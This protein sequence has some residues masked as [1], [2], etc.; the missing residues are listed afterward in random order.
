MW[1]SVTPSTP[2]SARFS[3]ARP[4]SP[5]GAEQILDLGVDRG[6]IVHR[7]VRGRRIKVVLR[8]LAHREGAGRRHLDFAIRVAAQEF[9]ILDLDRVLATDLADDARN[10]IGMA[11]AVEGDAGIVDVDPF[12]RR[13]EPVRTAFAPDFAVGDDVQPRLFLQFDREHRRVV[14]RLGEIRLGDPPQLL[15]P[16]A[17]RKAAGELGPVDQP[18]GLRVGA[19]QRRWQKHDSLPAE[20]RSLEHPASPG[21]LRQGR[22]AFPPPASVAFAHRRANYR[23]Q[24]RCECRPY[25][26]EAKAPGPLYVARNSAVRSIRASPRA[27]RTPSASQSLMYAGEPGC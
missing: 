10:G 21:G 5:A 17:G 15:R 16:H 27:R 20:P 24:A 26:G 7:G 13:R 2:S 4:Y 6:G 8:L 12:E 14:L 23:A 22:Q 11:G 3:A 9:Q 1:T 18:L 19:D 25:A